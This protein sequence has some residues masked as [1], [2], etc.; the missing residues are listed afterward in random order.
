MPIF[1]LFFLDS[2]SGLL[3]FALVL[4]LANVGLAATGTADLHDRDDVE[5]PGPARAR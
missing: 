3:P 5:R 4:L 2:A 1:A